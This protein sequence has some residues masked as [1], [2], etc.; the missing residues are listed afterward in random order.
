ML[1]FIRAG[2]STAVFSAVIAGGLC[3]GVTGCSFDDSSS[4]HRDHNGDLSRSDYDRARDASERR[5]ENNTVR[6]DIADDGRINGSARS[7]DERKASRA[8][9]EGNYDAARREAELRRERLDH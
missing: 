9:D 1:S 7:Y 8:A 3:I 4:W 2:L 5:G 6:S